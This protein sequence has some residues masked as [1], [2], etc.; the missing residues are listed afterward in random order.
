MRWR[1]M[2]TSLGL[3]NRHCLH[4]ASSNKGVAKQQLSVNI[5]TVYTTHLCFFKVEKKLITK[6]M[7]KYGKLTILEIHNLLIIRLP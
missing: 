1:T 4:I 2:N 7:E 6:G 3:R 5:F